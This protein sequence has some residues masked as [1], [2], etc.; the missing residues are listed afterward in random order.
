MRLVLIALAALGGGQEA[1]VKL[2]LEATD[3]RFNPGG[4][5]RMTFVI[6]N[7]TESSATLDEPA[8]WLDGLQIRDAKNTIVKAFGASR[9]VKRR[10][11][12]TVDIASALKGKEF[13]EGFFKIRWQW[14][15]TESNEV[16]VLVIRDYLVKMETN[17]GDL[18]LELL[19][20]SA[21]NH[22]KNFIDLIRKGYYDGRKFHR[23]I[24]G[25]MMQGGSPKGDGL[26]RIGAAVKAEFN[27][28]KH[29]FGTLSAARTDEPDSHDGQFFICFA[30]APFLDGKYTVFG[31]LKEGD[32]VVRAIE[33]VKTDHSPCKRC[34]K[35][36]PAALQPAHCGAH[37]DDKP[38][39]D[40]VMKK[41]TLE[42]IKR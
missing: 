2:R 11:G 5:M 36:L 39:V 10:H 19:P 16:T 40:V 38:D 13:D 37:H 42:E 3:R 29:V 7:A 26:G 15:G 25:F 9:E 35:D 41:V 18:T 17:F 30:A 14:A 28:Q 24:A 20:E 1:G 33:K 31:R 8:D 6:E 4:A 27:D 21:P 32:A 12:R 23:I 34:G 22:V